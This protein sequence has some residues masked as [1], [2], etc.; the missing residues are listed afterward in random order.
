[1]TFAAFGLEWRK[2]YPDLR[3]LKRSTR[4]GTA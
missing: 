3:D 2:T 1:M 4:D